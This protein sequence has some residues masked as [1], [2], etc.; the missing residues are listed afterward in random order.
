VVAART[1]FAPS[2]GRESILAPPN[3]K[4]AQSEK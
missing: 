3:R 4:K 2:Q 1:Y